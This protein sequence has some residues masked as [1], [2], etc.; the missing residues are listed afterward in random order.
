MA[1]EEKVYL[2]VEACVGQIVHDYYS[3]LELLRHF[4]S[5]YL[6]LT[7]DPSHYLLYRND[8]PWAIRQLKGKIKHVHLKDA[9]GTP[10]V[11]GLDFLFPILGEGAIDWKEFLCALQDIEYEGYLSAEFESF[12]YMDEVLGNNPQK[13]AKI[14][15]E[16]LQKLTR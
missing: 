5:P 14:T 4:D 8:I 1:E 16:S 12:K 3:T 15:M 13:A 6:G 11:F 7:L 9:V 2:A 10:G